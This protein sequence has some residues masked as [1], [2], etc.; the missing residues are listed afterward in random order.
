MKPVPS[1]EYQKR[2]RELWRLLEVP[3][4]AARNAAMSVA[5]QLEAEFVHA[6]GLSDDS[7]GV[8]LDMK[9]MAARN[10]NSF[11]HCFDHCTCYYEGETKSHVVVTQPYRK[12]G[13]VVESLTRSLVVP[14]Q[15]EPWI[16]VAP[17][18]AFYYPRH[19]TMIVVKFPPG[20][21]RILKAIDRLWSPAAQ[22][23]LTRN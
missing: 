5:D 8:S 12:P 11:D 14:G 3:D 1:K 10:C 21:E 17:E 16:I 9:M 15:V 23:S 2:Q 6:W 22:W 20:Y 4:G 7:D 13:E 19:A 18:W